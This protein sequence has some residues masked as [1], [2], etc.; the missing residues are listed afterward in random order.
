LPDI[1]EVVLD[2]RSN[3][4]AVDAHVRQTIDTII[5]LTPRLARALRASLRT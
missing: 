3:A 2:Y 5:E 4:A 1:E